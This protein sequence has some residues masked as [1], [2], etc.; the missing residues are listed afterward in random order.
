M[1]EASTPLNNVAFHRK[2]SRYLQVHLVG[3]L[4]YAYLTQGESQQITAED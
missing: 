4:S 1:V 3:H 2:I